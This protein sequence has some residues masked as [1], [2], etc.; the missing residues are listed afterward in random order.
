MQTDYGS[1]N[2]IQQQGHPPPLKPDLHG[3]PPWI[4][5]SNAPELASH[6]I[7]AAHVGWQ[8]SSSET[9]LPAIGR[10][11][12]KASASGQIETRLWIAPGARQLLSSWVIGVNVN[13]RIGDF[14]GKLRFLEETVKGF[15]R[16][17]AGHE[18]QL[19]SLGA[20]KVA[21]FGAGG[22]NRSSAVAAKKAVQG[23]VSLRPD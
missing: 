16:S 4:V 12:A 15:L 14:F 22:G 11:V 3:I 1:K 19:G 18:R 23:G 7:N 9:G 10:T 17:G 2:T 6:L 8:R 21:A 13:R 20:G 5:L